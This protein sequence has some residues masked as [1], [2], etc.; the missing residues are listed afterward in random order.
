M[1]NGTTYSY[2]DPNHVDVE[3]GDG[4]TVR[5][6]HRPTG[7]VM[8]EGKVEDGYLV[9]KLTRNPD[10]IRSKQCQF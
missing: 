8:L 10:M 7:I 3:L 9:L 1:Q 6:Y 5:I 2:H 4:E